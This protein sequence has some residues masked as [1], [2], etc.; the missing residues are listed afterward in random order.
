M[1]EVPV[2]KEKK[3]YKFQIFQCNKNYEQFNFAQTHKFTLKNQ[4][5]R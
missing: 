5:R 4:L 1:M 2:T 3:K